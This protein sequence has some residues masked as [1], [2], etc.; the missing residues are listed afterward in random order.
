MINKDQLIILSQENA[1]FDLPRTT[2]EPEEV[3]QLH[4]FFEEKKDQLPHFNFEKAAKLLHINTDTLKAVYYNWRQPDLNGLSIKEAIEKEI[5]NAKFR[6]VKINKAQLA[7]RLGVSRT[8]LY[9][10]WPAEN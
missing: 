9:K 8:T 7:E 5:V 4:Q 3:E 6:G 2:L 1:W 10:H